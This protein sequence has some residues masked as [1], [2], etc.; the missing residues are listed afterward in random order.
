MLLASTRLKVMTKTPAG[1]FLV[2]QKATEKEVQYFIAFEADI[3]Y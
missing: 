2:C 3:L 1:G